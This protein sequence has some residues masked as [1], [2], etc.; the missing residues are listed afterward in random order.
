MYLAMKERSDRHII[1]EEPGSSKFGS[2]ETPRKR[3]PNAAVK[4]RTDRLE[5]EPEPRF[6]YL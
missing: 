6:L 1:F 5:G 4:I 3:P 2:M